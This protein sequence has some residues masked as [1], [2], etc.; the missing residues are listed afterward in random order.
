MPSLLLS[1]LACLQPGMFWVELL[2]CSVMP[3]GC[4][5]TFLGVVPREAEQG[6]LGRSPSVLGC[7]SCWGHIQ[8]CGGL[9]SGPTEGLDIPPEE[10]VPEVD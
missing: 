8:G 7:P 1:A 6:T 9:T 10:P 3:A 2:E 5:D 4:T